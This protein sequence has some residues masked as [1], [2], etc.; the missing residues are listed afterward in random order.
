MLGTFVGIGVFGEDGLAAVVG[1]ALMMIGL[2]VVGI[3]LLEEDGLVVEE[4]TMV[5]GWVT[6]DGGLV[7][8]FALVDA[9]VGS[10]VVGPALTIGLAVVLVVVGITVVR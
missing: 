5:G 10:A 6:D 3:G 2:V 7:V 4:A 8:G 9:C 1:P